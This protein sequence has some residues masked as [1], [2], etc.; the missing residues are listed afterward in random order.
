MSS[1]EKG[2]G[3]VGVN[4]VVDTG[5]VFSGVGKMVTS[6][7]YTTHPKDNNT[8]RYLDINSDIQMS[9]ADAVGN[10]NP[11]VWCTPLSR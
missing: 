11:I 8:L 2:R 5:V 3:G 7:T 6:Y 1:K 4:V 9:L 10:D